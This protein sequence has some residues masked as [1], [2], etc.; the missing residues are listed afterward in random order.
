MTAAAL[1]VALGAA[2]EAA[3]LLRGFARDRLDVRSKRARDLLTEADL[4]AQACIDAALTAGLPG[5]PVLGE[6]SGRPARGTCW[7]VD[8]LDGTTNYVHGVP[9]CAVSIALELD[10]VVEVG[11][12]H[13]VFRGEVFAARRG[14]GATRDGARIAVADASRLDE[15]LVATGFPTG[16]ARATYDLGPFERVLREARCVRRAG[17]AALDLAWVADGRLGGFFEAELQPW[18]T[19]AGALLVREAG[20]RVTTLDGAPHQPGD[21]WVVASNDRVHEALLARLRG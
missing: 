2:A 19:A 20:G 10:G 3:A 16:P 1:A 5:V 14:H 8:P 13:D 18:D 4:A 11:V 9:H 21:R 7:I 6:E 17:A 15:V 12:I